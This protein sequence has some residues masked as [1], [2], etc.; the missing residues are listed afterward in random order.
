MVTVRRY[1]SLEGEVGRRSLSK[2]SQIARVRRRAPHGQARLFRHRPENSFRRSIRIPSARNDIRYARMVP[3]GS[4]R[5]SGRQHCGIHARS[6]PEHQPVGRRSIEEV[7]PP[8]SVPGLRRRT[9]VRQVSR[10]CRVA[11]SRARRS[12]TLDESDTLPRHV[13]DGI[14]GRARS[15]HRARTISSMGNGS[16][17]AHS[18]IRPG[19][20]LTLHGFL[21]STNTGA[22]C[23]LLHAVHPRR[24]RRAQVVSPRPARRR[25]HTRDAPGIPQLPVPRSQPAC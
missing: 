25:R 14:R 13:S 11:A 6:R 17:A 9:D 1:W 19:Q 15:R 20:R 23:A 5:A 7:F 21:A 4:R 3:R 2:R 22:R 10:L 18:R 24:R 12:R 16:S 8:T